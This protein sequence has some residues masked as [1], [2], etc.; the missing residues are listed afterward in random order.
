MKIFMFT[1]FISL[2][3][4]TFPE[5]SNDSSF[6]EDDTPVITMDT[7]FVT[8]EYRTIWMKVTAY[9][10]TKNQCDDS[11]LITATGDSVFVG[12]VAADPRW[13][14]MGSKIIIPGYNED[15][16]CIVNDT[17]SKIKG[18]RLD[19]LMFDHN[20]AIEWGIRWVKVRVVE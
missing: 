2:T 8:H 19:V 10:P 20:E 14:P 15:K 18:N 4:F 13:F 9:N 12:G 17:G 16:I 6:Y 7:I 5:Q 1:L 3:L 11:P